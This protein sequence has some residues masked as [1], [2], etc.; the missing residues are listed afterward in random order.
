M[1]WALSLISLFTKTLNVDETNDESLS[2]DEAILR[3]LREN[4][5]HSR[6][7]F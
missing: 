4:G 2:V 6:W 7:M 5:V 3:E 1:A